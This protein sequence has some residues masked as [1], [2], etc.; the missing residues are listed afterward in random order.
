MTDETETLAEEFARLCKEYDNGT[1]E[2]KIEAWN[3]IADFAFENRVALAVALASLKGGVAGELPDDIRIPLHTLQADVRYYFGR[4]AADGSV[5]G[6]MADSVLNRLSQLETALYHALLSPSPPADDATRST[7]S[8][9]AAVK[10][11]AI[12]WP[13]GSDTVNHHAAQYLINLVSA[14]RPADDAGG[15]RMKAIGDK[16]LE[17]GARISVV[18]ATTQHA[19]SQKVLHDA[20]AHLNEALEILAALSAKEPQ[21]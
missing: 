6:V 17:V 5:A 10:A 1:D 9:D 19:N 16:L 11:V 2:D 7:P 14:E 15:A 4:V 21:T 3:L 18:A 13:G 20:S 8:L 12:L